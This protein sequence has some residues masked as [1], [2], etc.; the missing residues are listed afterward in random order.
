MMNQIRQ[1]LLNLTDK[2]YQ[3]FNQKLCPDTKKK[4]IGI[5]VPVLRKLAQKI[6][7]EYDWKEF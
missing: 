4:M 7:K 5:R 2:E 3:K 6:V 1:E